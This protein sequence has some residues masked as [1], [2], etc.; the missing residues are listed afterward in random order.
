MHGIGWALRGPSPRRRLTAWAALAAVLMAAQLALIGAGALAAKVE[1]TRALDD[2]FVF[3]ADVSEERV[4]S[5]SDA[6]ERTVTDM[7]GKIPGDER[8]SAAVLARLHTVLASTNELG[9]VDVTYQNGDYVALRR[10]AGP[11]PGFSAYFVVRD[12]NGASTHTSVEYDSS[13]VQL[14]SDSQ[15]PILNPRA[16]ARYRAAIQAGGPV[17]S[18]PAIDPW[19]G[20]SEVWFS[21]PSVATVGAVVVVSA[22]VNLDDLSRHLNDLP[23]GSDGEVF[24]LSGDRQVITSLPGHMDERTQE[25]SVAETIATT[26]PATPTDRDVWG[27]NGDFRTLERGLSSSGVDWV[28]HL[29]A[30]TAGLNKGFAQVRVIFRGILLG[31]GFLTLAL[32]Y[33]LF[34]LWRPVR[35]MRDDVERDSLTGLRNRRDFELAVEHTL[36]TAERVGG[37]IAVVML[38]VDHFK[39]INDELGHAA[40]DRALKSLGKVLSA[41]VRPSDT[42]MRWGG[43]EFLLLLLLTGDDDA[44]V[45]V[46]S[47]RARLEESLLK[48]VPQIV[49]L[50]ITAG[51]TVCARPGADADALVDQADGA[52]VEGKLVAK[53]ATHAAGS[54]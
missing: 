12:I 3:L 49:D 34:R 5:Y 26:H 42:A 45:T 16:S 13:M 31:A 54:L 41:T 28:L 48:A 20:S 4:L 30:T 47:I 36:R 25:D 40:G 53:G 8:D 1:A 19:T 22:T 43:D 52:L 33:I 10:V 51:Y 39:R 6:V 32:G 14:S 17:W 18:E 21:L 7:N 46:E 27:T 37:C 23:A 15:P 29:H 44:G 50:G 2:T 9:A 35:V 11:Q 24:L 38:D